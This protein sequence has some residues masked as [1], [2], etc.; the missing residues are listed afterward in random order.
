M[1]KKRL[2][3]LVPDSKKYIFENV[4]FQWI[5]MCSNVVM[6]Y[7]IAYLLDDIL[8]KEQVNYISSALIIIITLIL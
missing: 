7:T 5:G 8:K 3:G 1:I 2:L 4:L 6:V